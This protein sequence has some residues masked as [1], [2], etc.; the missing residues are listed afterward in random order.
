MRFSQYVSSASSVD[1]RNS[2]CGCHTSGTQKSGGRLTRSPK[3]SGGAT[4]T[5]VN[6]V[7]LRTTLDPR[8]DGSEWSRFCQKAWL[9][10]TAGGAPGTSS[11]KPSVLPS[12]A[13]TPSNAK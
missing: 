3:N 9:T 13:S 4:P 5:M 6:A 10:T 11:G 8:L 12:A 1:G 2:I 7:R